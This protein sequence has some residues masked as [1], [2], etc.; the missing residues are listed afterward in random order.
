MQGDKDNLVPVQQSELLH[1]AL[2]KVGVESELKIFPGAG[3]GGGLFTSP[4]VR[5]TVVDF[6]DRYL[7]KR[8]TAQ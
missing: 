4:E 5:Q 7:G 6:F 8:A 2:R 3:H 1:A